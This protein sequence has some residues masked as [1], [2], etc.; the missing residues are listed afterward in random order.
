LVDLVSRKMSN[1]CGKK[2]K[3]NRI[4]HNAYN[5]QELFKCDKGKTILSEI[6]NDENNIN[7]IIFDGSLSP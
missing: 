6:L 7:W 4:Y 5:K 1:A 2:I 3:I